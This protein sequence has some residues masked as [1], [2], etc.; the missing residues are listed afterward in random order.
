[1]DNETPEA[2]LNDEN[3]TPDEP[4]VE[5]PVADEPVAAAPEAV[6]PTPVVDATPA[7]PEPLDLGGEQA[8]EPVVEA[9]TEA[10]SAVEANALPELTLGQG[11]L[12]EDGSGT[13]VRITPTLR[14]HLDE[15]GV[16]MGTG[17]RKT[18][19]AR[20]RIKDG[21]GAITINGRALED[22]FKMERDRNQ[23]MAPLRACDVEGTVDVWVRVKGGGTT[24]QA[25]AVVLGIA[26]AMQTKAPSSHETLS[27]GGYLTR[28]SRMVE[29]KKYGYKKA[30]KSFQFSKR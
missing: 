6:E 23:I 5:Q 3:Q 20:V 30:R 2:P 8:A 26:R 27:V 14:G 11:A 24:G 25:G 16:A 29:R 22:Y 13:Q 7:V 17:R 19:V 1:M 28:D 10:A 21:D 9:A 18:S 12:A 4:Q 15:F